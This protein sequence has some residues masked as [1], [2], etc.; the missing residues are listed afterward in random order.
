MTEPKVE[1]ISKLAHL[2]VIPSTM[3]KQ[4]VFLVSSDNTKSNVEFAAGHIDYPIVAKSLMDLKRVGFNLMNMSSGVV[5]DGMNLDM[6][7]ELDRNALLDLS[8][9]Y[10][11]TVAENRYFYIPSG[12]RRIFVNCTLND[13]EKNPLL[14][15]FN[16]DDQ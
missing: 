1:Y 11:F 10:T 8:S 14:N 15:V 16:K 2:E 5:I 9:S 6:L 13:Y 3:F 7:T 12:R 4:S